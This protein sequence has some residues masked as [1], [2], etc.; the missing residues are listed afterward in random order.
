MSSKS[1]NSAAPDN[2]PNVAL[3]N[4]TAPPVGA[5]AVG[6]SWSGITAALSA[7]GAPAFSGFYTAGTAFDP[8]SLQLNAAPEHQTAAVLPTLI[9]A[10]AFFPTPFI[11]VP[12]PVFPAPL[13]ML[14][15]QP[16]PFSPPAAAIATPVTAAPSLPQSPAA[17]SAALPAAPAQRPQTAPS[18]VRPP[19]TGDAG[20]KP[21]T[22]NR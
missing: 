15:P 7:S 16:A 6:A 1:I 9:A 14:P 13:P 4:L 11:P 22:G 12:Q 8:L 10:P 20:L 21:T 17:P 18:S 3:L 2:F 5:T 19:V